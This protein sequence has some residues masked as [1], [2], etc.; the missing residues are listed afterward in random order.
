MLYCIKRKI[1]GTFLSTNGN[2]SKP[3][4]M[5]FRNQNNAKNIMRFYK[6]T[7]NKLQ[8]EISVEKVNILE[9]T[10]MCKNVALDISIIDE[11]ITFI[12]KPDEEY[13]KVLNRSFTYP[14]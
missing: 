2:R 1:S 6:E 8:Q 9:L 3:A 14:I 11:N 5:V 10:R 4:I 7:S 12:L 13:I